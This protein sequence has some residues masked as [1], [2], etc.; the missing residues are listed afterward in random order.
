MKTFQNP[1]PTIS[2]LQRI[3]VLLL[4]ASLA[5]G[6]GPPRTDGARP[7][8]PAPSV[9]ASGPLFESDARP[10]A[11]PTELSLLVD[12][13]KVVGW[14]SGT[15]SLAGRSVT[16]RAGDGA[17]ESV[18]IATDNT[19]VWNYRVDKP[20]R[21]SFTIGDH[22]RR[23]TVTPHAI[24]PSAYFVADR[25]VY[26][27][28]QTLHFAAFLRVPESPGANREKPL[29][30]RA[31][32]VRLES[33]KKGTVAAR[34]PLVSDDAG[35][36][37]GS[38]TFSRGDSL[39]QYRL[40]IADYAGTT[41]VELAEFRKSKV[42]VD[43]RGKRHGGKLEL[44]FTARDFLDKPVAAEKAR[45][46]AQVLRRVRARPGDALDPGLF[47]HG[48][49]DSTGTRLPDEDSLDFA[50][51]LLARLGRGLGGLGYRQEVAVVAEITGEVVMNKT[52]GGSHTIELRPEWLTDE[53]E[54]VVSAMLVDDNG[55]EQKA[56]RRFDLAG[57][58]SRGLA[59]SLAHDRVEVGQQLDLSVALAGPSGPAIAE[60]TVVAMRLE[61]EA[62][63]VLWSPDWL[64]SNSRP[65][66]GQSY[67]GQSQIVLN[68]RDYM[69]V[70]RPNSQWYA[71]SQPS[72]IRRFMTTATGVSDGR[73]RLALETPGA[74]ELVVVARLAD[75]SSVRDRI[76]CVVSPKTGGPAVVLELD[77]SSYGPGETLSG[78]VHSRFA[79][80]IVLLSIRD[81]S[82][83][84]A[85]RSIALRGTTAAF[86]HRLPADLGHVFVVDVHYIDRDGRIHLDDA[87][88][89]VDRRDRILEISS[90][91]GEVYEP[92]D[93]VELELQV[94]SDDGEP[95]EVDLVV[96]VYDRSLLGIAP[97]RSADVRSFYLADRRA[98]DAAARDR[99]RRV[100]GDLSV[101]D[102]V[103]RI[104]AIHREHT[105]DGPSRVE[106]W[107]TLLGLD[108]KAEE[109]G[110]PEKSTPAKKPD[111]WLNAQQI[112]ELLG[113]LDIDA[114]V[115][116]GGYG[117]WQVDIGRDLDERLFDLL[118][119]EHGGWRL[120]YRSYGDT[121]ALLPY[122][123][124]NRELTQP[125]SGAR[126]GSRRARARGDAHHSALA[127]GNASFSASAQALFSHGP[128]PGL[129]ALRAGGG[130]LPVR[131]N[132]SDSA[133]FSAAIRTDRAGRARSS[134]TLPDSLTNWQVKV[135][136]I[137]RDGKVGQQLSGFRTFKPIMV[138]PMIPRMFTSGDEV[139]L[140]AMVHN[141][142]DS[143]ERITVALEVE[144]GR[145]V[146]D[147]RSSISVPAGEY[148]PVY[149]T[150]RPGGPGLTRILM[151]AESAKGSDASLKRIPVLASKAE[152][153]T[154]ASGVA[155]GDFTIAVP[156]G[157]DL[158]R[159][160]LEITLA[161]S[162]AADMVDTL[163]YL[164]EYPYGCVEQTM[165]RFLPAV[166]VAQIL[167]RAKIA[168]PGL[169]KKLPKV[170]AAGIKRLLDL[171]REDGGWGWYGTGQTHEM[172]TPYALFGLLEAEKAGYEI[173]HPK[174]IER[175]LARLQ[176]FIDSMGTAQ[177][178]DRIYSMY[179][180]AQRKKVPAEWWRF[181]DGQRGKLSDYALALAL[182]MAVRHD[183]RR[184]ADRLAERL[185]S[186]AKR[187]RHGRHFT[188][189]GFSRWGDDRFEITAAALKALVAYRDRYDGSSDELA[190]PLI[191][192][193]IA[194]FMAT[195]RG[196]RW[197]ST[198]D[199]A[200]II[201]AI[202]DYVATT[203]TG[204]GAV[205][206]AT[207]TLG[208]RGGRDEVVKRIR[209]DGSL[210]KKVRLPGTTLAHGE[211]RVRLSGAPGA[212]FRAVFR[213]W[214]TGPDIAA[215]ARGLAVS[216]SFYLVDE[217]GKR[218]R[219][220]MS[221]DSVPRG[222]YI[223]TAVTTTG[224]GQLSYVVVDNPKPS[225]CE[226]IAETDRRFGQ[227]RGAHVLREDRTD[228]TD[229]HY[230]RGYGSVHS[231]AILH[232]EFAGDFLVAPAAAELLYQTEIRGHS[233][234]FRLRVGS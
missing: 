222:S 132:F 201:Y 61:S 169:E 122:R 110:R 153:I 45:F 23:V 220:L 59:L 161:P 192:D 176:G 26:R 90:K 28:E 44:R 36:V 163:D 47:V 231:R 157:V 146:G 198:K 181:I 117:A 103:A 66:W 224:T 19:F 111:I 39:G 196:D 77:R 223:E 91:H 18:N 83:I 113:Y 24:E 69:N 137:S 208:G 228:G 106:H 131:R 139:S 168:H 46:T 38:Y 136:A 156:D 9:P 31:V 142:T 129:E 109:S 184:L 162:L 37:V 213:H 147:N 105:G 35:R 200:M 189:A 33:V 13:R 202:A 116:A 43:I 221:G 230:E 97:D 219:E 182:E 27:P 100:I 52:R 155:Q 188:T 67:W 41:T 6:L 70:F 1:L 88:A 118:G 95:G 143:N 185:R 172:M 191:R 65:Y 16:V 226:I 167:E 53:H 74:Y 130:A 79:D 62:A 94:K 15:R 21:V 133:F 22:T 8:P 214:T 165:S 186:R 134:F 104:R 12:D 82:G 87:R 179:V 32:E 229:Y 51:A 209:L 234:A 55:R 119:R 141:R 216:R 96:S 102:A 93:K 123:P 127:G 215:E 233:S 60:A 145:V 54:V 20:T 107:V 84:R 78:R 34:I 124:D 30:G 75:G 144:N 57:E 73:A 180:V 171:Q 120:A 197:N 89:K 80:A 195:K 150:F 207:L 190:D 10:A 81:G 193:L 151:T 3:P 98:P 187:D 11:N 159:A 4:T 25:P 126:D 178:A 217:H 92:G 128:G 71:P 58:R 194:F 56:V 206:T 164:V 121:V 218:L 152:K 40:S 227:T 170:A 148:R 125:G 203:D 154:T 85:W 204:P 166:K 174:A 17:R 114:R 205:E 29:S 50:S 76:G 42:K 5:C 115:V 177:A 108:Q 160:S 183:K 2:S 175:G 149:W 99:V 68:G 86:E 7:E 158:E 14:L 173:G 135:V 212:V 112:A 225:S 210:S 199:T 49:R 48:D 101:G 211:N 63:P 64:Y 138:W 140:Y 232:A 72:S